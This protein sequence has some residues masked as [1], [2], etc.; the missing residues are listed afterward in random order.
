[1]ITFD[2]NT[3]DQVGSADMKNKNKRALSESPGQDLNNIKK[4]NQNSSM[5]TSDTDLFSS[6]LIDRE[7]FT[8]QSSAPN[9]EHSNNLLT[10]QPLA[11]NV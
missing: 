10:G 11:K 6:T 1:M 4:I 2:K 5:E 8:S 7:T 9:Q 3:Q